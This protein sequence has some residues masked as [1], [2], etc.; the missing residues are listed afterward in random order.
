MSYYTHSRYDA[1]GR[2]FFMDQLNNV[3]SHN[4][5]QIRE[6]K[7]MSLDKVSKATGVSKSMLGQIERGESNPTITTV[8]KIAT[9]LKISFTSLLNQKPQKTKITTESDIQPL[10]EDDGKYKLYPFFPYEEGRNFD[11][12]KVIIEKGGCLHSESHGEKVDEFITVF[13][14]ELTLLVGGEEFIVTKGSS[15]RFR[16]DKAH[17]YHNSGKEIVQLSMVVFYPENI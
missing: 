15:I 2:D 8:W 11:M 9:G 16:A 17:S 12:H 13:E 5:K 6:S 4:L 14:G 7:N 10:I 1:Q 3:I